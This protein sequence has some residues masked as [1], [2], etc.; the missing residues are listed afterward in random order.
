M[1][2]QTF[3]G[4]EKPDV[5]SKMGYFAAE[6][7]ADLLRL[8]AVEFCL[9][10]RRSNISQ[11]GRHIYM[12]VLDVRQSKLTGAGLNW[13]WCC[14]AWVEENTHWVGSHHMAFF[15][16]CWSWKDTSGVL[17]QKD[18]IFCYVCKKHVVIQQYLD[19]SIRSRDIWV[20]SEPGK[21]SD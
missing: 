10:W 17:T 20:Y 13:H 6:P 15:K 4:K 12:I 8:I 16:L 5:F 2:V 7:K 21:M 1:F 3:S 19:W 11:R 9:F 18:H 14:F